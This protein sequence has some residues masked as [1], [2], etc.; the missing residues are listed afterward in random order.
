MSEKRG[1]A[2]TAPLQSWLFAH[3]AIVIKWRQGILVPWPLR[4]LTPGHNAGGA[5][6]RQHDRR[7]RIICFHATLLCGEAD[8]LRKNTPGS[9]KCRFAAQPAQGQ[10]SSAPGESNVD[11]LRRGLCWPGPGLG[12]NPG[13]D[14]VDSADHHQ[15]A[16]QSS[17]SCST[18]TSL[19]DAPMPRER[20]KS[21]VPSSTAPLECAR[22]D[23]EVAV[24]YFF[25][26]RGFAGCSANSLTSCSTSVRLDS[27]RASIDCASR[28][29]RSMGPPGT[30][31]A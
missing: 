20:L 23:P 17:A 25:L 18:A 21:R 24:A 31:P 29:V 22:R 7:L 12:N 8:R 4:E 27:G 26:R 1:A 11:R 5:A 15:Q 3:R 10:L 9:C 2:E 13:V 6:I 16:A 30:G 14:Y 19:P 28:I